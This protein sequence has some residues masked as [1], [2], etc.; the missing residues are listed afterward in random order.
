MD[1]YKS[2]HKYVQNGGNRGG[3]GRSRPLL[4]DIQKKDAFFLMAS[5]REVI[6]K[7]NLLRFGHCP[8][9]GGLTRIQIVRG[10]IKKNALVPKKFLVGVQKPRGGGGFK[11]VSTMSK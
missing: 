10:T 1:R 9:G 3:R 2:D 7:K 11:A 4:D 8:K 5:L 6:P